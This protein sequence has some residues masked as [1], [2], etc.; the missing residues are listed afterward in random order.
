MN[1]VVEIL[2]VLLDLCSFYFAFSVDVE[3]LVCQAVIITLS[4]NTFFFWSQVQYKI[5][6]CHFSINSILTALF[7]NT[8]MRRLIISSDLTRAIFR[9]TWCPNKSA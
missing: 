5:I 8:V 4:W 6:I 3:L 9:S 2:N 1:F 7:V